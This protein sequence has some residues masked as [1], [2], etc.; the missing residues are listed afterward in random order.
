M[1]DGTLFL[2]GA[3]RAVVEML[4][5]CL[6][7]QAVLSPLARR[8]GNPIHAL[9]ALLTAPPRRLV[10]AC[11]PRRAGSLLV[12]VSTFLLLFVVWIGLAVLRKF[13]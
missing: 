3:L 5:L 10:A 9:F 11:L 2:I 1:P 6:L 13:I 8:G 4:G 7:G 12:G